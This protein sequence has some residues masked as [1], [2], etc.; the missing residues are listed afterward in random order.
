MTIEWKR[1]D[2]LANAGPYARLM[3]APVKS[4]TLTEPQFNR[5][6]ERRPGLIVMDGQ[7]AVIGHPYRDFLEIHYGFPDVEPFR[8]DFAELFKRCVS[9]SSKEEAP[10]GVVLSFR[11]RPNRSLADTIFW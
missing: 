10:R 2:P 6:S 5:L 1:L 8:D 3:K 11:D 4:I 9:A 7:A